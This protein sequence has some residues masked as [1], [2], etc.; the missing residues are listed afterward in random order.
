MGLTQPNKYI[1]DVVFGGR[2]IGIIGDYA[3]ILIE[4][5]IATSSWDTK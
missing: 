4:A 3:S 2:V 1:E 5:V